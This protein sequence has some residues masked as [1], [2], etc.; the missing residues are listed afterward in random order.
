METSIFLERFVGIVSLVMGTSMVLRRKMLLGVFHELSENRTI[1]YILGTLLMM[2]GLSIVLQHNVWLLGPQLA[3][4]LFGWLALTEGTSYLFISNR[5][6]RHYMAA[7]DNKVIY[8]SIG[9][10][11]LV[12]GSYLVCAGFFS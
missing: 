9:A 11:Y 2:V 1:S 7:L 8:F 12:L 5:T 3:V 10:S 4:T 6:M